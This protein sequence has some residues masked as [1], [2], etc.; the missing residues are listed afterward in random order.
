MNIS[1]ALSLC[2]F[3]STRGHHGRKDLH[4]FALNDLNT[5]FPLDLFAQRLAHVKVLPD[6][7]AVADTM[8]ADFMGFGI[9]PVPTYGYWKHFDSSHNTEYLKDIIKM[10]SYLNQPYTFFLEDDWVFLTKGREFQDL[11]YKAI[12]LLEDNP[13]VLSVR[14]PRHMNDS[15]HVHGMESENSDFNK[16]GYIYSFNP[17]VC[18]TRDL[19]NGAS[20]VARNFQQ[21]SFHCEHGFTQAMKALSRVPEPFYAFKPEIVQ[22]YH[23]GEPP[24]EKDIPEEFLK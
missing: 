23:I 18:R 10:T 20:I 9:T 21:L 19:Y 11:L 6:E 4:K 15:F 17:H 1:L 22:A 3:S 12:K 16:N 13:T 7:T 8:C 24:F 2:V 14:F 5:K